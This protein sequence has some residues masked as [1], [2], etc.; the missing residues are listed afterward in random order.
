MTWLQSGKLWLAITFIFA[1]TLGTSSVGHIPAALASPGKH[2]LG[3]PWPRPTEA[4]SSC[5]KDSRVTRTCIKV[6]QVLLETIFCKP[7]PYLRPYN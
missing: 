7:S 3:M 6:L 5:Y 1:E 2:V 4:E